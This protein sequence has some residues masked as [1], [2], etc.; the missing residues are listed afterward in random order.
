MDIF[1]ARVRFPNDPS[2]NLVPH[3]MFV[4]KYVSQSHI[5]FYSI[6]SILGKEK[7]VFSEDGSTNEEIALISGSVQTDNGFKV[8][9]FVDCS[10]GYIVTLDATVDIERLNHRSLTPEL[11]TKIINKVNFLKTAG[12]HTSYSISLIDFISWNK[13]ILRW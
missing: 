5:E 10:K 9:S 8:P 3:Q 7:R 13:K 12:K 11:Y 1:I 2:H 4:G 6:S